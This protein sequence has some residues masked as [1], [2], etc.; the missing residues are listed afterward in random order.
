MTTV[1]SGSQYIPLS[2]KAKVTV[3][4]KGGLKGVSQSIAYDLETGRQLYQDSDDFP[5][6]PGHIPGTGPTPA[7]RPPSPT[8]PKVSPGPTFDLIS[9]IKELQ[10]LEEYLFSQLEYVSKTTPNDTNQQND[11]I[12]HINDLSNLRNDLFGQL[13]KI[14]VNL[15]KNS[16]IQRSALTDQ[17]TTANMME[18]QMNNLKNDMGIIIDER[19]NK[20]RI[21]EIGEYEY[22]RYSAHKRAMQIVAFTSLA[23]LFFFYTLKKDILQPALSKIGIMTAVSIGGVLVV[24]AVWDMV[25]RDN[26]NYNRFE[27]PDIDIN[28]V[29]GHE[30]SVWEHDK[31][32]FQKLWRGAEAEE[33]KGWADIKDKW[34]HLKGKYITPLEKIAKMKE[35]CWGD[36]NPARK[37][38]AQL[39]K[40]VPCTNAKGA[41][42][43]CA[44]EGFQGVKSYKKKKDTHGAPFN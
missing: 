32:F 20:T 9:S 1:S 24:K 23:I 25:T 5:V 37:Y 35:H 38:D 17:I 30:E 26:Q 44:T 10:G 12:A 14:Y 2:Q 42:V 11:I 16:Q 27:E 3:D 18:Q 7:P 28:S 36:Y 34:S 40:C 4:T 19:K 13:G 6:V 41:T 39:N 8:P 31:R 21:V 29:D 43:S 15:D 22:L 33:Q